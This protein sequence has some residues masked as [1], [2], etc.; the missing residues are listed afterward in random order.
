MIFLGCEQCLL[1]RY[2]LILIVNKCLL[3]LFNKG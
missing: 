3:F 1:R 2:Y